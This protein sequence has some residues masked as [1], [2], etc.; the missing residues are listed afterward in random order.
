MGFAHHG[1]AGHP[2]LRGTR[3]PLKRITVGI[4]LA[5]ASI[6]G[7]VWW[8]NVMARDADMA[9]AATDA[10]N[11][12]SATSQ[13]VARNL[14][15]YG[16]SIQ[17]AVDGVSS[18]AAMA[19]PLVLRQMI[20]FDR[21]STASDLGKILVIDARGRPVADSTT[22]APQVFDYSDRDYFRF[23]LAGGGRG[24]YVSDPLVSR[25]TGH[26]MVALSRRIDNADGSFGGVV[27]GTIH[28]DYFRKLF[29]GVAL[30]RGGSISL[31]RDD[32][33]L[34]M[35]EPYTTG[36][37]QVNRPQALR[38]AATQDRQGEYTE[39]AAEGERR[40][41]FRHVG[42]FPLL[43]DV[44]MPTSDLERQW[45]FRTTLIVAAMS[46]CCIL[47]ALLTAYLGN[48]V[49]LRAMAEAKLMQLAET[50]PLTGIANRRC[51]DKVIDAEWRRAERLGL[52]LSIL[53]VDADHFK[54]YNDAYGH[55]AGDEALRSLGACMA[56]VAKRTGDL[57]ARYGGEEFSL[58]LPNTDAAGA[59]TVAE[60]LLAAI[61]ARGIAHSRSSTGRFT[62]SVGVATMV[63][64]KGRKVEELLL[65]ADSALYAAKSAG[66]NRAAACPALTGL[67]L[68]A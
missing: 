2:G 36:V 50:D 64:S 13:D 47:I 9:R 5:L 6:C 40:H 34:L 22:L 18:P 49:R 12:A 25:S 62:A 7:M 46:A 39:E 31:Y 19:L 37:G 24:L 21:A 32:G 56:S 8:V 57:A 20:L 23:H 14:E 52:P 27:A 59:M 53:M 66:R 35:R 28:L 63:P 3:S 10:R 42:D 44:T 55:G 68:V 67:R 33:M 65:A 17:G 41:Y 38:E 58:V 51:L 29:S 60:K 16:L 4:A 61:A 54:D 1:E 11:V 45:R 43:V 15:I 26:R 48:Q 30:P